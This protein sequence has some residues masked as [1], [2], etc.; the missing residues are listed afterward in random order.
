MIS[1]T[2]KTHH[3]T[4][5][6]KLAK[7]AA[8]PLMFGRKILETMRLE[9]RGNVPTRDLKPLK[10]PSQHFFAAFK[11]HIQ[12]QKSQQIASLALPSS[13]QRYSPPMEKKHKRKKEEHV[14]PQSPHSHFDFL[15][16]ISPNYQFPFP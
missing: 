13:F 9:N 1:P 10:V 6:E 12:P 7:K 11:P 2:N 3:Q 14:H 5:L 16:K 15:E 8:R 4:Q